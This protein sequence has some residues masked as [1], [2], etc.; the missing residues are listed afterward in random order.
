MGCNMIALK[1]TGMDRIM[2]GIDMINFIRILKRVCIVSGSIF[3]LP[4]TCL[5]KVSRPITVY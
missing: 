1:R 4:E 3:F 2:F 5:Q